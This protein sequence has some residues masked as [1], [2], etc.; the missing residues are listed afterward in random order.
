[1]IIK[2]DSPA[3]I[4]LFLDVQKKRND[5]YHEIKTIM[6]KINLY[7]SLFF[8]IKKQT[9]DDYLHNIKITSNKIYLPNNNKNLCYKAIS[10][11][12]KEF[13]IRD[14][15]HLNIF[16]RIPISA[17]LGGG[18]SNFFY[19]IKFLNEYYKLKLS[20]DDLISISNM[21]GSDIAFF[22]KDVPC[23]CEGRGE[24]LTEIPY[25]VNLNIKIKTPN[26][27]VSTKEIFELY[28]NYI[29]EDHS[30]NIEN[31]LDGLKSG[32]MLKIVSNCFNS[33]EIVTIKKHKII[34]KIK[35][36]NLK[37]GALLSLMSGSGPSVF[38]IY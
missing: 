19:T 34:Q 1:M 31:I 8:D 26:I 4:N 20:N 12:K 5:G 2:I 7:D 18:S 21:Y 15:I 36:E 10:Y 16:K 27:K 25:N 17:G 29:I 30:K 23:L 33:L 22:S 6:Q 14:D 9:T 38:S 37:N 11:F 28:D 3:K 24:I 35:N 13:N 32:N